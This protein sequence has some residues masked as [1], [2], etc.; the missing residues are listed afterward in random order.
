MRAGVTALPSALADRP[1]DPSYGVPV[2]F[3]CERDDGP[4]TIAHLNRKRLIQCALSRICGMCGRSL[5]NP[6]VFVGS[7]QD[8]DRN[9]FRLA[10]LHA[11]CADAAL[12]LYAP[13]A[14]PVLD[15]ASGQQP[16]AR[17]V[18]GG[19]EL[20]RPSVRGEPLTFRP[21]S[22]TEDRRL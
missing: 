8:A 13:L 20:E 21:N 15:Y 11:A 16:W 22:I 7:A 10:P 3:A 1:T 12:E 14:A 2:P 18:T 9:A 4:F 5:D 17:V 19:F 6:V